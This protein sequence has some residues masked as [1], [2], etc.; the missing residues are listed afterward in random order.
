M[1]YNY[2]FFS[3]HLDD[4]VFSC[5]GFLKKN[6]KKKQLVVTIFAGDYRGLTQWDS[7]CNLNQNI[8]PV[9][10]RKLEDKKALSVVRAKPLYYNFLDLAVFTD[11]QEK[12][13]RPNTDF[14][15]IFTKISNLINKS[16]LTLNAIFFPLGINHP[17]HILLNKV[18]E[19]IAVLYPDIKVYFY[20]D[21]PY[22]SKNHPENNKYQ[23]FYVNIDSEINNKLDLI[24]TYQSQLSAI[25]K[26]FYPEI[27][28]PYNISKNYQQILLEYHS[29]I[30]KQIDKTGKFYERFWLIKR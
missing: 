15:T 16:K 20:E 10:L 8:A 7:L 25:L 5:G 6:Y 21:F 1:K 2:I 11:L 29:K 9:P 18:G 17:D 24:L 19:K 14:F 4:V 30:G 27:N 23:P 22:A 12:K 3:P 26:T 13:N 28:K